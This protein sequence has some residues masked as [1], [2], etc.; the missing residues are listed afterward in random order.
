MGFSATL[1]LNHFGPCWNMLEHVVPLRS[2]CVVEC[3]RYREL[4]HCLERLP[5]FCDSLRFAVQGPVRVD[6][7]CPEV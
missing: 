5:S 2:K 4:F 1:Q 7:S 3:C 6:V